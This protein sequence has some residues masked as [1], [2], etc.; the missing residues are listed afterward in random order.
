MNSNG[1]SPLVMQN[2]LL[3]QARSGARA[4][5][6]AIGTVLNNSS[7]SS[8]SS[9]LQTAGEQAEANKKSNQQKI[10]KESKD[11]YTA[12]ET[13][14]ESLKEHSSR[15]FGIFDGEWE[16]LTEE[17]KAA[18]RKEAEEEITDFIDDYNTLVTTLSKESG[19]ANDVYLKQLWDYFEKE[20]E[21]LAEAGITKGTDGILSV[22]Q[23]LLQ[24]ADTE[25]L[26]E[27]FGLK[28]SFAGKVNER[29]ENI[30]ANAKTNLS[31]L[32]SSLYAG[33]YSYNKYGSDVFDILEGG[34]QYSAKG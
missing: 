20:E 19:N 31:V 30:I 1:I 18:Y 24:K 33:T 15:L 23:E 22:N 26:R 11:N 13:A 9:A 8:K 6:A 32:N 25:K 17:E 2:R 29:A 5:N 21:A 27:V 28:G 34:S 3:S 14:A 12:M 7:G 4:R 16:T 10:I